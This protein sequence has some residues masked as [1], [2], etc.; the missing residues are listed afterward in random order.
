MKDPILYLLILLE[1]GA[2][3]TTISLYE[4]DVE[5]EDGD[6]DHI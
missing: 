3:G 1:L 5:D 2:V 6:R 4:N